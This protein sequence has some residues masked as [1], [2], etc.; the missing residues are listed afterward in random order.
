MKYTLK[1]ASLDEHVKNYRPQILCLSGKPHMR[2]ALVTMASQ[3]TR[4]MSMC[5]FGDIQSKRN[6]M[7]DDRVKMQKYLDNNDVKVSLSNYRIL[8]V[9][10]M[11]FFT[12]EM[13]IV[14]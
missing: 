3:M 12:C 14:I 1:L 11:C 9:Y 6:T 8:G 2:P 5:L 10:S 13:K 4:N 7:H